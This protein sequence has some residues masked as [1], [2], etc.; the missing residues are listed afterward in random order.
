M[1]QFR[2]F[3]KGKR[4]GKR[5]QN[6]FRTPKTNWKG[7][8]G[9]THTIALSDA[10]CPVYAYVPPLIPSYA[11]DRRIFFIGFAVAQQST[12]MDMINRLMGVLFVLVIGG[13]LVVK[14]CQHTPS[15]GRPRST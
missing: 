15:K 9:D 11:S 8:K 6:Y 7:N 13:V 3:R 14:G 1:A 10:C 4:K 5:G 12:H 2:Q